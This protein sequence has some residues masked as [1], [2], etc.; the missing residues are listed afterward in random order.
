MGERL[1]RFWQRYAPLFRT[2]TR[3]GS[4]YA[5][6]YLSG[7]LRLP[8]KRTFVNIGR[9]AGVAGQNIQHFVSHSPWSAHAVI[10]RVQEEIRATPGLEH[11]GMLLLDESADRKAGTTAAGTGRQRNGRVGSVQLSQGG[12]FLAY[13]H[14]EAGVW[15]WVDGELFLPQDWCTAQRT[16]HRARVGIPSDRE[17]ATKLD[18]GWR[19]MG[20]DN[21]SS[22]F[23]PFDIYCLRGCCPFVEDVAAH[24]IP[25]RLHCVGAST[26]VEVQRTAY[27]ERSGWRIQTR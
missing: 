10:A 14:V 9:Q 18:L 13:A 23:G 2:Q 27:P 3:D 15:T 6:H 1:Q 8:H 19:M 22:V 25:T 5:Y 24:A 21:N 17:C 20:A 11:G 7:L 4:P 16:I 12:T 26:V